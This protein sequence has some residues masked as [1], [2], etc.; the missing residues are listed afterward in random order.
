MTYLILAIFCSTGNHL[1]FKSFSRYKVHLLGAVV[2]NYMV[3]VLIGLGSSY[4]FIMNQ[5][6]LGQVWMPFAV[7]QGILLVGCL[8]LIGWTTTKNGVS[9]ASSTAPPVAIVVRRFSKADTRSV[10]T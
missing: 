6:P 8:F 10:P 2:T 7:I 4:H 5:S 3:C 9:V 1:L